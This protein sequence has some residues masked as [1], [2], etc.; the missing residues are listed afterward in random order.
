[1]LIIGVLVSMFTAI[2]VTH[3]VLRWI[4]EQDR[5]RKAA[6]FGVTDAE[7]LARPSGR[8][9]WEARSRV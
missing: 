3:T 4:V 7:F 9:V 8:P 6:L 2:V 5:F 1:M